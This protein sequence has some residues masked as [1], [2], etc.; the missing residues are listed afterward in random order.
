MFKQNV[1]SRIHESQP[2]VCKRFTV[3]PGHKLP[4]CFLKTYF[5][6]SLSY[7]QASQAVYSLQVFRRAALYIFVLST[8]SYE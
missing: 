2:L 4:Y 1:H 6:I 8:L 7:S 5:H 3:N